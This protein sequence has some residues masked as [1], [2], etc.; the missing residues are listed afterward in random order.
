LKKSSFILM[1]F[2]LM[3]AIVVSGCGN[4]N[5]A[6]SSSKP[7]APSSDS[8]APT[9]TAS[10]STAPKTDD[11]KIIAYI[12][13]SLQPEYFQWVKYGMDQI[14]EKEGYKVVV[15]DSR[16]STSQQL[17]NAKTAITAGAVAI[18]FSPVSST[19]APSVLKVAEE[20]KVPIAFAAIGPPD[21]ATNYTSA[22]T[23]KDFDSGY[24]GGKYLAQLVKK[25]GGNEIGVLSLPQDRTNAKNK[26]AGLE[27]AVKEEGIK[28]AQ[29][30]QTHDDTVEEQVKEANDILTAHPSIK[31]FYAM[32]DNA[33]TAAVRTL[34]TKNLTGKIF[35]V[36]SDGSPRTID[37]L[38]K[39]QINGIVTQ[40]AVGQGIEATK[41]V[42]FAIKGEK[43]TKD[44]PLP[45]PLI[46]TENLNSPEAQENL[47]LVY[48][49]NTVAK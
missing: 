36:S 29:M 18:V 32:S 26:L 2:A 10:A 41:Q 34:E 44:L 4:S 48:P 37:Y 23:S 39:G 35:I 12:V 14:G 25:A 3:L 17:S 40:Q 30:I 38:K 46:T 5:Q 49:P 6:S 31:G 11:K 8:S 22:V 33:G 19:S 42:I 21:G 27:K 15:Y 45:E 7:S 13:P 1:V 16:N 20:A 43:V 24:E 28:I 9:S 47:K